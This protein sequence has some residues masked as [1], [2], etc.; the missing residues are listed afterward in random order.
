MPNSPTP[1]PVLILGASP[2]IAIPIARLLRD[3]CGVSVDVASVSAF[4]PK[5]SSR[6]IR[7]FVRLPDFAS[8]PENFSIALRSL[9]R[10]RNHDMLIPVQ[11]AAM[12]AIGRDYGPLAAV[13]HVACPPPHIIE[14]V[15]NKNLTLEIA[16]RCH[17]PIPRTLRL[18]SYAG[19]E[20]LVTALT[21]PFIAKPVRQSARP[22][23]KSRCFQTAKQF[24]A[25]RASHPEEELLLQ[26]FCPGEG[27]GIEMLIHHGQSSATFQHRRLKEDPPG[28]GVAVM[29]IAEEPDPE[30]V[31]A[32]LRLL[33]GLEWEGVAMVEFRRDP[34]DRTARLMEVNGRYWGTTALA[35]ASGI[36]FPVYQWEILHGRTPN[37]RQRYASGTRWRWTAGYLARLH[38]ILLGSADTS[39]KRF[40]RLAA[41]VQA[42]GDLGPQYHDALRSFSDPRPFFSE[43]FATIR[44]FV[45]RDLRG[46]IKKILGKRLTEGMAQYR[47]YKP[48][49]QQIYAKLRLMNCLGLRHE[50]NRLASPEARSFLFVCFGN[51]MRSP[52]CEALLKRKFAGGDIEISA[53]SA[54]LHATNGHPALPAALKAACELGISLEDH[55]AQLLTPAMVQ[56]ADAIFA[57]DYQ[58]QVELLAAYPESKDKILMLSS[59]AG[60]SYAG[61]EIKDPYYGGEEET[62]RC[63]AILNSCIENLAASIRA[64][65]SAGASLQSMAS[66]G[67]KINSMTGADS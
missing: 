25:W 41:L 46:L 15:L 57:M 2:R 33:R 51:I 37:V 43:L 35:L 49:E 38:S 11:D 56:A 59:Y 63:Y 9:V 54:G 6:A 58:N 66:S 20:T 3:R 52:M 40:S 5:L 65:I 7:D 39:G 47:K 13:L 19:I 24:V 30:L 28:G 36:E 29:A 67:A 32:S 10:E 34:R 14:R 27:V 44:E 53:L 16:E 26:E 17:I 42:P 18:E 22:T 21:F 4:D 45:I 8:S 12:A 1:L 23:F 48:S 31:S 62:R 50:R 60:N 55:A 64:N 61:I